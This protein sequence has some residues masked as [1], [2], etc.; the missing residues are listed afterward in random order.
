MKK[1]KMSA[2]F[3]FIIGFILFLFF[4]PVVEG[5]EDCVVDTLANMKIE[6]SD[7]RE[8]V[9]KLKTPQSEETTKIANSELGSQTDETYGDLDSN[10]SDATTTI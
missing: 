10:L 6:L 9:D 4:F 5:F 8:E 7:L 2:F 1:N 3:F